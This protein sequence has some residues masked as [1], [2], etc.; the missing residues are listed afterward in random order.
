MISLKNNFLF[1]HIPKTAGNSVQNILRTY[2][3]D[4]VVCLHPFQDGFERFGVISERFK[5]QKHSILKDYQTALDKEL[6]DKLFKF[7]IVRN[8]WDRMISCYFSPHLGVVAWDRDQFKRLIF[9]VEPITSF[10]SLEPSEDDTLAPFRNI[11]YF[12][13]YE[14][15]NEDFRKV[16]DLVGIPWE[17]LPTRNKSQRKSYEQYYDDELIEL[18]QNKFSKEIEYFNY[19]Y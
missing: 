4:R 7:T 19:E 18:V 11:D 12:I 2:S 17:T 5:T 16:C 14:N 6:F 9:E 3:E 8:P 15:L 1:V 13:R 10:L